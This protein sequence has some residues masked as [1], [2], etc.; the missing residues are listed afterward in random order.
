MG[1]CMQY[2]NARCRL[3]RS[4]YDTL[5]LSVMCIG[6]HTC[7]IGTIKWISDKKNVKLAVVSIVLQQLQ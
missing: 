4:L 1:A 2:V 3:V 7:G 5:G 6:V